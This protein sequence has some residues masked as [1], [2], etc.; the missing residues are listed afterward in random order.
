[1]CLYFATD[2]DGLHITNM[3]LK[4]FVISFAPAYVLNMLFQRNYDIPVRESYVFEQFIWIIVSL[5]YDIYDAPDYKNE[6]KLA[7]KIKSQ[8]EK[9][10]KAAEDA[11][12]IIRVIFKFICITALISIYPFFFL[13]HQQTRPGTIFDQLFGVLK[14]L[15]T[16]TN[17]RSSE[18]NQ[19]IIHILEISAEDH[20]INE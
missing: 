7:E 14:T 17:D 6:K 11:K 16:P 8:Q 18:I 20:V 15:E 9:R 1:M 19:Q 4:Y 13:I 12:V 5:R 3:Y 2:L 10:T